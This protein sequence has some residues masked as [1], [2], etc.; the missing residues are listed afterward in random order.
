MPL[1]D[2]EMNT[3]VSVNGLY[4][5]IYRMSDTNYSRFPLLD[6]IATREEALQYLRDLTDKGI[7]WIE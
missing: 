3:K 6:G 2:Q 4:S 5:Y 1:G 7:K